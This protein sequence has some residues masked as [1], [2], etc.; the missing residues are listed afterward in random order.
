MV[1]ASHIRAQPQRVPNTS[2]QMPSSPPVYGYTATKAFGDLTFSNPVAI[3]SPP[4]ETNR[5]F[6]VEQAGR[7]A[8]I[9]NLM[10]PD[11]TVFLDISS[12]VLKG[13]RGSENGLLG[14]AFHPGYATN[15]FF[16][17]YYVGAVMTPDEE[18][19]PHD[20][21]SRFQVSSTNDHLALADSEVRLIVQCDEADNHNGGDLHFGPDGYLYV[22]FGDEGG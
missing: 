9:T 3:V 22:L 18:D 15:G 21:L 13:G 19:Q 16:Y 12:E 10:S 17:L 14:M 8:I 5:L 11:R 7:V 6:I 1:V 20:I 4:G 2:L